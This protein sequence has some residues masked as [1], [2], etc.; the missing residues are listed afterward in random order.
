M[1]DVHFIAIKKNHKSLHHLNVIQSIRNT[2]VIFFE[3][4]MKWTSS[5]ALKGKQ[6]LQRCGKSV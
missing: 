3:H 4:G 6:L 2:Y 1:T 5:S